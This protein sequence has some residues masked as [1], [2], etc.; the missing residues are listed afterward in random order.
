MQFQFEVFLKPELCND[1][2]KTPFAN[3]HCFSGPLKRVKHNTHA[4]PHAIVRIPQ[5]P[6]VRGAGKR[7]KRCHA[8]SATLLGLG[9]HALY[10][11]FS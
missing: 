4:M 11:V 8:T 6:Q 1:L 2:E 9:S 5:P 3:W 7:T 10:L